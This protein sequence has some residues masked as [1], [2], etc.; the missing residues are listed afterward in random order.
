MTI[1]FPGSEFIRYEASTPLFDITDHPILYYSIFCAAQYT[2]DLFEHYSV[3]FPSQ[4]NRAVIKRRAEFLAGRYCAA[5]ALMQLGITNF[6]VDI[7]PHRN[8][9]WPSGLCGSISH[10]SDYAMAVVDPRPNTL[11]LGIDIEELVATDAVEPVQSQIF[12]GEELSLL[13]E[14][15]KALVFT[16]VFSVKESFFKAAYPMVKKYF[17]FDAVSIHALDIK[18]KTITLRINTDLCPH[19][20][21]GKIILGHFCYLTPSK[22]AT[23]VAIT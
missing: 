5:K 15:N 17:N 20:P 12:Y 14:E 2:D 13:T 22:I 16:L 9:L 23:L 1:H 3:S 7:G 19:L 6:T 4:L 18:N 8:P 11:G 10:C 21:Q